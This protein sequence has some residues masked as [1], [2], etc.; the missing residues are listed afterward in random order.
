MQT[1]CDAPSVCPKAVS[2]CSSKMDGAALLTSWKQVV[3]M[4]TPLDSCGSWPASI[5]HQSWELF[6]KKESGVRGLDRLWDWA[7]S[8]RHSGTG[9]KKDIISPKQEA[10]KNPQD[11]QHSDSNWDL[12]RPV[13]SQPRSKA[14]MRGALQPAAQGFQ[15]SLKGFLI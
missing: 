8:L 9:T 10:T 15:P 12:P 7:M 2:H 3:Q 4:L 11:H 5:F 1:C 13:P 14:P 6:Y